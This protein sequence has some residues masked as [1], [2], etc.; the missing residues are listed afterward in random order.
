MKLD[1]YFIR[2]TSG[3][4]LSQFDRMILYLLRIISI[5]YAAIM[6]ARA[7]AYG[8]SILR[9]GKLP[10]PVIS[11]GNV[12]VGGTGKTPVTAWVAAYL[13]GKGKRVVVLSRGY[14]G[15]LEGTVA[16]VS[17]G[18][19]RILTPLEAGD[20]PC[21]LADNLPG[22][23]VVIGSSRYD[24]G[25]LAM[26]RFQPDIFILDDGFQHLSLKRD[27][28]IL[29]LDAAKPFGNGFV[30]PAGLLREPV[31]AIKRADMIFLTRAESPVMTI[32]RI[33]AKIPVIRSEHRLSGYRPHSGG[34][35]RSFEE[36]KGLKGLAFA[37]IAKPDQFFDG[38]EKCGVRLVATLAFPDHTVYGD[39]E[40]AALAKLRRSSS[41]DYLI[42]T[43]KDAVK[44]PAN[45][46]SDFPFHVAQLEVLFHGE[47]MLK[48]A[49]DKL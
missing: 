17:D 25:L 12:T 5:G 19:K 22:L 49:L 24:A 3:E 42:T 38:L 39:D 32:E 18:V 27:L 46:V 43:A 15:S 9:S 16:V 21:L 41:A 48:A 47:A 23:V 20:E 33:P 35:I 30:F 36:L 6:R 26:E 14:G 10:R 34:D 37:G 45:Q 44:M 31:S 7:A 4:N 40:I 29:L 2:L 28:N 8:Q 13:L 11:I 1:E